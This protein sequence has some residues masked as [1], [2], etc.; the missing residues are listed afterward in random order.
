M[1]LNCLRKPNGDEKIM[2]VQDREKGSTV[3]INAA[4]VNTID[5]LNDP[6]KIFGELRSQFLMRIIGTLDKIMVFINL[7]LLKKSSN[8]NNK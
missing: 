4:E 5:F 3:P 8:S 7:V 6:L 2:L 1:K